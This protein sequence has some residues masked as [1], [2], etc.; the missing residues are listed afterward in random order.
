MATIMHKRNG[1]VQSP[2]MEA[3]AGGSLLMLHSFSMWR[4]R[5]FSRRFLRCS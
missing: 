5:F 2:A 1:G 4:C 3:S